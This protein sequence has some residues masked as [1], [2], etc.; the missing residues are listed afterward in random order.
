MK[1]SDGTKSYIKYTKKS[2]LILNVNNSDMNNHMVIKHC[3][4]CQGPVPKPVDNI[5][6][7]IDPIECRCILNNL[8]DH[9]FY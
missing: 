5:R 6:Y 7:E 9:T 2:K 8:K 3:T 4:R 1:S